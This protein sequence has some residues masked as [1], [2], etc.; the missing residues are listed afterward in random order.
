MESKQAQP[1][2]KQ[3]PATQE[4]VEI[5]LRKFLMILTRYWLPALL[6][7]SFVATPALLFIWLRKPSYKATGS[8][9]V[10]RQVPTTSVLG[11]KVD[12]G[13]I[14]SLDKT[15][16][17]TTQAELVKSLPLAQ[18]TIEDLNLRK[19]DTPLMT[20]EFLKK[21][22]VAPIARSDILK[23]EYSSDD[24]LEA[25]EVVNYLMKLYVEENLTANRA[26]AKAA[27]EFIQTQL[28]QV[29]TKVR[30]AERNIRRFKEGNQIVALDQEQRNSVEV[31][32]DL[33]KRISDVRAKLLGVESRTIA[34]Q[35]AVGNDPQIATAQVRLSQSKGVQ[36]TLKQYQ[37]L[38]NQLAAM[39]GRYREDHPK[40]QEL[41]RQVDELGGLLRERVT[42]VAGQSINVQADAD[43]LQMGQF[44]EQLVSDLVMSRLEQ[45]SLEQQAQS[46]SGALSEH[47]QRAGLLPRLATTQAELERTL[48]AAQ[49]TYESLLSKLQEV[50]V[51]EQQQLGNASVVSKALVPEKPSLLTSPLGRV[52]ISLAAGVA[53][54]LVATATALIVYLLD[55]RIRTVQD[56]KD[57]FDYPVL[58]IIPS[59]T[60]SGITQMMET[61]TKNLGKSLIGSELTNS[62]LVV[63]D[64]PR[65]AAAAAY[66]MLQTNLKF[67]SSDRQAKAIV[68]T[69]CVAGEGKST[70]SANL[71]TAI[72]QMGQ[73]VLLIDA[74]LRRPRQHHVWGLD[75]YSVGFSNVLVGATQL[76]QVIVPVL[77]NLY[78]LPAGKIPP[79]PI[80]L[81]D[82]ERMTNL[83]QE[84]LSRFDYVIFDT[85]PLSGIADALVLGKRTD[86]IVLVSRMGT[87]NFSSAQNAKEYLN[88]AE[89]KVLGLVMNDVNPKNEPDSY[90][91]GAY[92]YY[93]YGAESKNGV[94]APELIE[95]QRRQ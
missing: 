39:L 55:R 82:S 94:A 11:L 30:Q 21:L 50:Q 74:D 86:G 47:Q 31:T 41:K 68:V 92:Y 38:Q 65:S 36:E 95:P 46:L 14:E 37:E 4:P 64:A 9:L 70:A 29:E 62:E 71:A 12:V 26:E 43:K 16:P 45:L 28:P 10:K 90:F 6:A 73:R 49:I 66:Q 80:A 83:V 40:V 33:N 58:G 17:L 22:K 35:E 13:E 78:I 23:V 25:S 85:P 89:Q 42:D 2:L 75:S 87:V 72:A 59:F 7:F 54:L 53:G 88:Q 52:L 18:R 67:I 27:R 93:G 24:P 84:F 34:L 19:D 77:E 8:V 63:R 44:R 79:N 32:A 57:I 5:D 61:L 20:E 76:D 56:L 91:Y 69:S 3:S 81:L 60:D 1:K 48:K 15:G 51:A